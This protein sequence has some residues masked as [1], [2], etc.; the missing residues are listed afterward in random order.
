MDT[1][2]HCNMQAELVKGV[3]VHCEPM[4]KKMYRDT[5][6]SLWYAKKGIDQALLRWENR[7]NEGY[8][9]YVGA[10]STHDQG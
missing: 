10:R 2:K 8:M 6:R 7:H 5:A 4:V 1:C 9:P 3:C